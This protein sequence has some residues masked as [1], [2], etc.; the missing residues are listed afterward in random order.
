MLTQISNRL[1]SHY[2]EGTTLGHFIGDEFSVL[3]EGRL[4]QAETAVSH[5]KELLSRLEPPIEVSGHLI[6]IKTNAGLSAAEPSEPRAEAMIIEAQTAMRIA[7]KT[8]DA[9][10]LYSLGLVDRDLRLNFAG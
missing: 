5:T 4:A 2:P 7:R 10:C 9:C 3:L 1:R 6:T 8:G